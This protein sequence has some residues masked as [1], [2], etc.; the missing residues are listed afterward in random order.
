MNIRTILIIVI[1]IIILYY[2]IRWFTSDPTTLTTIMSG[3]T[4]TTIDYSSLSKTENGSVPSNFTYSMWFYINDWNYRYGEPKVLFG[5][6]AST[7]DTNSNSTLEG[8]SGQ[9]PC[10]VV[11][12][13]AI[14]NN[15]DIAM[16]VYPSL[17]NE[18]Q[19]TDNTQST[20]HSCS[21]SIVPSQTW[22]NLLISVYGR[23]LDVYLDGKLVKSCVL[24]GIAKVNNNS[25][26][27]VTPKGGFSGWTSKFQYFPNATDPQTAWNIYQKGPTN[28][29]SNIWG[30]YQVKVAVI[31]NGTETGSVTI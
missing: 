12:L 17:S 19:I 2:L 15:L 14:S 23:T 27:Y 11:V 22:V 25:N 1:I 21:L 13:G 10:P 29:L 20:I 9:G 31:D 6:M 28:S 4:Q 3:T 7:T 16:T 18:S 30:N 5:R 26:V 24:P 8:V